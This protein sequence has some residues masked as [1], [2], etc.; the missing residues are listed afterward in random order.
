MESPAASAQ[1]LNKEGVH[2]PKKGWLCRDAPRA[3]GAQASR[4]RVCVTVPSLNSVLLHRFFLLDMDDHISVRDFFEAHVKPQLP[5]SSA[6]LADAG[7]QL[8]RASVRLV[9]ETDDIEIASLDERGYEYVSMG[10]KQV[11]FEVSYAHQEAPDT[12]G[13]PAD[14]HEASDFEVVT[15]K[16]AQEHGGEMD[17]PRSS[18]G[19]AQESPI[20]AAADSVHTPEVAGKKFKRQKSIGFFFGNS[21]VIKYGRDD[22]GRKTIQSSQLQSMAPNVD[23]LSDG[24]RKC[25]YCR[26]SFLYGPAH[27]HHEKNCSYKEFAFLRGGGTTGYIS[28]SEIAD[29]FIGSTTMDEPFE[30]QNNSSHDLELHRPEDGVMEGQ[31]LHSDVESA[32]DSPLSSST[33]GTASSSQ[34]GPKML[35]NGSGYKRSG[36]AQGARRGASRSIYFKYEVVMY[37]REMQRLKMRDACPN[38]GMATA[39]HFGGITPGQVSISMLHIYAS[40]C[41]M[42][43]VLYPSVICSFTLLSARAQVS[44]WAKLEDN[45][46]EALLKANKGDQPSATSDRSEMVCRR[47]KAAR[48]YTLHPGPSQK[49]AAA[50]GALHKLYREKRAKGIRVKGHFLRISMKRFVRDIYGEAAAA[51]FKASKSWLRSQICETIQYVVPEGD[52][53]KKHAR[54]RA[55]REE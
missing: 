3:M 27:V 1:F 30:G 37:Y 23:K 6:A 55:R 47:S 41:D 26:R 45:L 36:L 2:L 24:G 50:E 7:F 25:Q 39:T 49:F 32:A 51:H 38:P 19:D 31:R 33:P 12:P 52:E 13:G 35:K 21:M 53:Q 46:K 9:S 8:K 11:T 40:P 43:Y 15:R 16:R 54:G 18:G 34:R 29:G 17:G 44:T 10:L 22:Q 20:A 28:D 5:S 14:R 42:S 48:K 4:L